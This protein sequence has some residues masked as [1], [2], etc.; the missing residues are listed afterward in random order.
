[1][2]GCVDN[3]SKVN[4]KGISILKNNGVNVISNV[5][6][7]D[8]IK[9]HRNFLH[10]NEY[11]KP[12]IIL[13]WAKSKDQFIAPLEKKEVKSFNISSLESR[14]LVH[15]WRSEEHA[16]LVGYQTVK[17][18]NPKLTTR[19]THMHFISSQEDIPVCDAAWEYGDCAKSFSHL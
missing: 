16:I 2:I 7:E 6:E 9:L 12:Y 5:L 11:K 3:S 4:G 18:D 19:H 1:M 8:C 15:K 10:F 14:Q 17:D 13:K